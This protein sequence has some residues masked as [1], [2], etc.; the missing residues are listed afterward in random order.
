MDGKY[1]YEQ[2]YAVLNLVGTCIYS[3]GPMLFLISSLCCKLLMFYQQR[4]FSR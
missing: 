1:V 3:L 4:L 2:Y